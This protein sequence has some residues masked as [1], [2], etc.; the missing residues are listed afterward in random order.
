VAD[1]QACGKP[2]V[3]KKSAGKSVCWYTPKKYCSKQCEG[4]A[5][6]T[7]QH[8]DKRGYV[9]ASV[10]GHKTPEH[11]RIMEKTLGRKLEKHET[12]HHKNGR[13]SD[14]RPEN[15]ELWTRKHPSGQRVTDVED[16]WSGM[17]PPYQH[18]AVM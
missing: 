3:R 9:V 15:L 1:C 12:V 14:N 18:N 13:R 10:Y 16:I 5:R 11:R 6:R 17:V 8:V 2:L 4:D 7:G